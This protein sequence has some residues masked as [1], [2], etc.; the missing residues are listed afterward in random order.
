MAQN[1]GNPGPR[2]PDA[3]GAAQYAGL[4]VT[5]GAAIV[6]SVLLGS[7]VDQRLGT[8]PWGVM[9]GVFLGFGLSLAWIYR[10][11]VV[12]PRDRARRRP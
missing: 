5:F 10:R 4:G 11:L 6:L 7:W 8:S 9:L 3:P 1:P 2:R 12:V